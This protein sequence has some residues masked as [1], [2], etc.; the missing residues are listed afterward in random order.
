MKETPIRALRP[1]NGGRLGVL[2]SVVLWICVVAVVSL[3]AAGRLLSAPS[4]FIAAGIV[5]LPYLTA[6]L[7]AFIVLAWIALP[8]RRSIPIALLAL[9]AVA[10]LVWGPRF[11]RDG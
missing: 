11:R 4:M 7:A 5:F 2:V 1:R 3:I 6:L 8:D 9:G 10:A